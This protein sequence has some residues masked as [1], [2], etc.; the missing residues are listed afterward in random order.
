MKVL[1]CRDTQKWKV[2]DFG[3]YF[4]HA[5]NRFGTGDP[6]RRS[7]FYESPE[8]LSPSPIYETKADIWALGCIFY[9]L[10]EHKPAFSDATEVL[11][12]S[13]RTLA[14]NKFDLRGQCIAKELINA[15]LEVDMWK[16]P[17]TSHILP[18]VV[19]IVRW[20]RSLVWVDCRHR[21]GS[22][23]SVNAFLSPATSLMWPHIRWSQ[24][25]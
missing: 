9:E 15:M 16:R 24:S 8:T 4:R 10:V 20:D 17:E 23:G 21:S 18:M 6:I 14:G 5:P 25:W 1:F 7:G 22:N 2:S 3:L 11:T 19:S 13:N 12:I